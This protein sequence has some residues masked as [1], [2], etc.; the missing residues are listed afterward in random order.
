MWVK[1]EPIPITPLHFQYPSVNPKR[2]S[3]INDD[4]DAKVNVLLTLQTFK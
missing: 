1:V 4:V 3:I 2:T